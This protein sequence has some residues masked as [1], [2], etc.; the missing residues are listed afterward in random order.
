MGRILVAGN[1]NHDR[2]WHLDRPLA[3]GGRLSC[4]SR[5]LRLGGG[6][7]HTGSQLLRLGHEVMIATSLM[8]DEA[9]RDA[10]SALEKAGFDTRHIALLPGETQPS[11]ILLDPSGERT[12]IAPPNRQRPP[13]APRG[14]VQA[15]AIYVNAAT[16]APALLEAMRQSPLSV[17]QF[18]AREEERPAHIVIGSA[19]DLK[20]RGMEDLWPAAGR[21]AGERLSCLVVTDGPEPVRLYDGARLALV[22][23]PERLALTDTIG[24]GDM[25]A[26]GFL[27]AL[28]QGESAPQAALLACRL[29]EDRLLE[30]RQ[31]AA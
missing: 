13:A 26:G 27:H 28:L 15:D 7:F 30:R 12:I 14:P 2:I 19:A 9:G 6:A 1:V 29:T 11:D 24:A 31:G 17:T 3:P 22:P 8:D 4:L 25:F 23:P 21:V 20:G 10:L 18:P 5:E 16:C